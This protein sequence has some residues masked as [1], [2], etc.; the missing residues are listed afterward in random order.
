MPQ[1]DWDTLVAEGGN[2]DHDVVRSPSDDESQENCTQGL[3]GFPLFDENHPL[4]F[5]HLMA[6]V[7]IEAFC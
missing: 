7:G 6:E 2:Q 5:G 1:G 3:G 4:S